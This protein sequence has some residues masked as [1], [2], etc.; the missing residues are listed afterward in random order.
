MLNTK[1]ICRVE[2]IYG[3]DPE[4]NFTYLM[5]K[6]RD[7]GMDE[8]ARWAENL[9]RISFDQYRAVAFAIKEMRR[10][11]HEKELLNKHSL[12]SVEGDKQELAP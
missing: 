9:P 10:H 1:Y 3:T 7:N 5:D 11:L 8:L 4:Y 2:P 12:T 6:C